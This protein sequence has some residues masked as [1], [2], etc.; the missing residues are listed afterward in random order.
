[1]SLTSTRKSTTVLS[2]AGSSVSAR[3]SRTFDLKSRSKEFALQIIKLFRTLPR[4]EEARIIGKQILR[5]GTSVGANYRAAC[6]SRSKAEFISKISIVLEEADET[7][8]WLELLSQAEI[9]SA[10][11]TQGLLT[12]ANELTSIFVSSLRTSKGLDDRSL[13]SA[14]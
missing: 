3:P 13:T 6:R 10:I 9:T 4:S 8:F 2:M 5:S 1:M 7:V 14:F 11:T 12:E